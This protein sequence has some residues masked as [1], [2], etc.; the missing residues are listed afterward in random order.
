M[1]FPFL[2]L[3]LLAL[4]VAAAVLIL[5]VSAARRSRRTR[6]DDPAEQGGHR[7]QSDTATVQDATAGPTPGGRDVVPARER[8]AASARKPSDR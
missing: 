8:R 3:V 2:L 5:A 1:D 6:S 4:P 7:L